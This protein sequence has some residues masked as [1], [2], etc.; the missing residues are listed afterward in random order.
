MFV[1]GQRPFSIKRATFSWHSF[2]VTAVDVHLPLIEPSGHPKSSARI[3]RPLS[4]CSKVWPSV[5]LRYSASVSGLFGKILWS[6][7]RAI[8]DRFSMPWY[9]SSAVS[10]SSLSLYNSRKLKRSSCICSLISSGLA[11]STSIVKLSVWFGVR[12]LYSVTKEVTAEP[13][14]PY[15]ICIS[16]SGRLVGTNLT[17]CARLGRWSNELIRLLFPKQC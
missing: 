4:I 14:S 16:N 13:W 9:T 10:S 17:L 7:L 11:N 5:P 15:S 2:A 12:F 6:V 8:S 1:R 3:R